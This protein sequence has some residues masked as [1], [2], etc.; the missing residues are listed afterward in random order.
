[1][2]KWTTILTAAAVLP[3]PAMATAQVAG[4]SSIGIGLAVNQYP[5]YRYGTGIGLAA[6]AHEG[7]QGGNHLSLGVGFGPGYDS[8]DYGYG[9]YYYDTYPFP[10]WP[11]HHCRDFFRF[12]PYHGCYPRYSHGWFNPWWEPVVVIGWPRVHFGW[13]S[14][15]YRRDPYYDRWGYRGWESVPLLR[16][17]LRRDSR[18][19]SVAALRTPLQGGSPSA[20]VR[21]GQRTGAAR[22]SCGAPWRPRPARPAGVATSRRLRP[23]VLAPMPGASLRPEPPA[24]V[25]VP[26]RRPGKPQARGPPSAAPHLPWAARR[27]WA[28]ARRRFPVFVP[29]HP[30]ERF[31]A[32]VPRL[33]ARPRPRWVLQPGPGSARRRP[34]SVRHRPGHVSAPARARSAPPRARSAPP[35]RPAS[36]SP[37]RSSG[38]P[39]RRGK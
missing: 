11:R 3:G 2:R 28:H 15:S 39:R 33:P 26:G 4:H 32:R 18:G 21:D 24:R 7:F 38:A 14:H 22:L 13:Y 25:S 30:G 23:A 8:H 29:P 10:L 35:K 20:R 12:D 36:K 19:K 34:R 37:P 16:Q 31:P 17:G 9:D 1:M 27:R 5:D 6:S